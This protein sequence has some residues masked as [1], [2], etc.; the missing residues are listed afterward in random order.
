MTRSQFN[1]M[2]DA[3]K[4]AVREALSE[5]VNAI[6]AARIAALGDMAEETNEPED[7]EAPGE[8][9]ENGK[10]GNSGM[11]GASG[12]P[13]MSGASGTS[14]NTG[15]PLAPADSPLQACIAQAGLSEEDAALLEPVASDVSAM[16]EHGR[17]ADLLPL[18]TRAARYDKDVARAAEEGELR[19]RNAAVDIAL[20]RLNRS[21]GIPVTPS[22]NIP[23][24]DFKPVSIFSLARQAKES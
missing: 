24:A 13:G 11:S 3:L 6:F 17:W 4:T 16:I 9:G 7:A 5:E 2:A 20:K 10:P 12:E 19:G 22:A 21:D 18:L 8:P 14:G 1:L 23:A 15:E